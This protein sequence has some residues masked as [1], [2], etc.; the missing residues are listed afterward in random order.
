MRPHDLDALLRDPSAVQAFTPEQAAT[1]LAQLGA[2]Q[3]QLGGLGMALAARLAAER[4][5]DGASGPDRLLT[6]PEAAERLGLTGQYV[7]GLV[8]CGELAS[9]RIG[10]YI[11]VSSAALARWQTEREAEGGHHPG[12][13]EPTRTPD[14]DGRPRRRRR[15]S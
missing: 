11:R 10:K 7:R 1:V 4:P 8:Q 15:R 14:V 9:V 12:G 2:H 13:L 5:A 3:A 6:V